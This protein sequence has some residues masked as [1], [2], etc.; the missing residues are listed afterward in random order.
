MHAFKAL[1]SDSDV[2]LDDHVDIVCAITYRQRDILRVLLPCELDY[3]G[4]LLW[5]DSTGED[6]ISLLDKCNE[7]DLKFVI[8]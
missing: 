6:N 7:L 2:G 8:C 1:D 3:L 4:L 5:T